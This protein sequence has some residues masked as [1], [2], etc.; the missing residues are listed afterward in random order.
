MIGQVPDQAVH[1]V[2][3]LIFSLTLVWGA[4][5]GLRKRLAASSAVLLWIAALAY[6]L[7]DE[8][9]QSFVPGRTSSGADLLADAVG[10]LIGISAAWFLLRKRD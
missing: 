10:A 2:G 5:S 4:T 9:H 8:F 6:G 7:S 3:Y 1:S